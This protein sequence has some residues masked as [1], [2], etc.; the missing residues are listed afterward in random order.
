MAIFVPIP[1]WLTYGEI[2]QYLCGNDRA[3]KL[4]FNG[5]TFAPSAK[6]YRLIYIVRK[7]VEWNYNR[8]STDE[9]LNATGTYFYKLISGFVGRA[10]VILGQGGSGAIVNPTTAT[11]TSLTGVFVQF[12]VGDPGSLMNAGDTVLT[13]TYADPIGG[14]VSVDLDGVELPQNDSTMI[15]YTVIYSTTNVV[16]TFNSPVATLQLY[17]IRFLRFIPI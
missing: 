1:T 9:T 16:I 8:D 17:Q 6:L 13:L 7:S 5:G 14:T 11:A 3:R 10:L 4:L 12:K 15:S 2:A